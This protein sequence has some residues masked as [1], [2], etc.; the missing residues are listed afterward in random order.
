VDTCMKAH[1]GHLD[2][3]IDDLAQSVPELTGP[4]VSSA[5]VPLQENTSITAGRDAGILGLVSNVSI[6]DSIC[7][8][9][10]Y[11]VHACVGLEVC[12][13]LLRAS[14]CRTLTGTG[15][16]HSSY[17]RLPPASREMRNQNWRPSAG[18]SITSDVIDMGMPQFQLRELDVENGRYTGHIATFSN[19]LVFA[20]PATGLMRFDSVPETA[21]LAAAGKSGTEP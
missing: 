13:D 10:R 12:R 14:E 20:S 16:R 6:P 15:K 5:A 8:D 4:S 11:C 9:G 7:Y 18:L 19:S 2:S 17:S 1:R 3:T 21:S